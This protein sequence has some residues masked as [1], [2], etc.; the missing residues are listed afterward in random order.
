MHAY[1]LRAALALC[2]SGTL[3][4]AELDRVEVQGRT[5]R[6]DITATCPTISAH[7]S[8]GLDSTANALGIEGDYVVHFMLEGPQVHTCAPAGWITSCGVCCGAP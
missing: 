3:Q 8:D 5:V 2:A 6:T 1:F 7:L 4:A